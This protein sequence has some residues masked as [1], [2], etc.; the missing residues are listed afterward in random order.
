M[1]LAS[2]HL[3]YTRKAGPQH[4]PSVREVK[5][6]FASAIASARLCL[7]RVCPALNSIPSEFGAD[8]TLSPNLENFHLSYTRAVS[9][10]QAKK[11]D[12]VSIIYH[13]TDL[14]KMKKIMYLCS[15]KHVPMPF[16]YLEKKM[17][18][19]LTIRQ[20]RSIRIPSPE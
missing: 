7:N 20:T 10:I 2:F 13:P 9:E 17:K 16:L 5:K 11:R 12:F 15:Y 8:R 1:D 4:F 14:E 3:S 6:F 18:K 19:I